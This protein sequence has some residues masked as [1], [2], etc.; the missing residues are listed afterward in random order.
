M[1]RTLRTF[2]FD[3]RQMSLGDMIE[4]AELTG[5]DPLAMDDATGVARLKVLAGLGWVYNRVDDPSLTFED[6]LAGR[7]EVAQNGAL[8]PEQS[9]S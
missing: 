1:G 9:A 7:V 5:V 2:T 6:V 3:P 4:V 8:P